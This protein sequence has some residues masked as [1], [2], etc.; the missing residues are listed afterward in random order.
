M[1]CL[2]NCQTKIQQDHGVVM[3]IFF[4][5][6]VKSF[7]AIKNI[8]P[9]SLDMPGDKTY[10]MKIS[11][12]LQD[13]SIIFKKLEAADAPTIHLVLKSY[14]DIFAFM[15]KWPRQCDEFEKPLKKCISI[16]IFL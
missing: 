3:Q 1:L 2:S 6:F 9:E 7:D 15:K 16:C 4:S 12:C 13:F 10:I 14:K 8:I 5:A 11:E